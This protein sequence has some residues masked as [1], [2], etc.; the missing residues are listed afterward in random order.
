MIDDEATLTLGRYRIRVDTSRLQL[1][2]QLV[3]VGIGGEWL[4]YGVGRVAIE[5]GAEFEPL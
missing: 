5:F 4:S 1:P 2:A 3:A